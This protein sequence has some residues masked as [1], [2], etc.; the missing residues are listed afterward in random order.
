MNGENSREGREMAYQHKDEVVEFLRSHGI[1]IVG[2]ETAEELS[3]AAKHL[4]EHLGYVSRENLR[5]E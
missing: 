3:E 5:A 1:A 4:T 2:D